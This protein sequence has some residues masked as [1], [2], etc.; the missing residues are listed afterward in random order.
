MRPKAPGT[1]SAFG[2]PAS[3][4]SAPKNGKK[5]KIA[6]KGNMDGLLGVTPKKTE[7]DSN[8]R[9][10]QSSARMARLSGKLI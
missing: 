10:K 2:A 1:A 9:K 6:M 4:T 3:M 8:L 5:K 7:A